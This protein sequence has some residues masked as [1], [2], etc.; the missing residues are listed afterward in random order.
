M[1]H[2]WTRGLNYLIHNIVLSFLCN[3]SKAGGAGLTIL[4]TTL[5]LICLITTHL[6]VNMNCW[7]LIQTVMPT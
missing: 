5:D 7:L 4:A 3:L 6:S 2:C 1:K